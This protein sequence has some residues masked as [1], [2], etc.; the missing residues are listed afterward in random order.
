MR[1]LEAKPPV[2]STAE[3]P[4]PAIHSVIAEDQALVRRSAALS[5]LHMPFKDGVV[6]TREI[7]R[8]LLGGSQGYQ[9]IPAIRPPQPAII[10]A[11]GRQLSSSAP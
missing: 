5:D 7:T 10:A 8:A 3:E 1:R 2:T 9:A 11:F 4:L 6:A